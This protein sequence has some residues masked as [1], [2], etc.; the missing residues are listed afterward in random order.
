MSGPSA[1]GLASVSCRARGIGNRL[2]LRYTWS[3]NS[4]GG[5]RYGK[6][7]AADSKR[8]RAFRAQLTIIQPV[9]CERSCDSCSVSWVCPGQLGQRQD[10]TAQREGSETG[11]RRTL[12]WLL[13]IRSHN[14]LMELRRRARCSEKKRT[15][16]YSCGRWISRAG[17]RRFGRYLCGENLILMCM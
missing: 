2:G 3:G 4:R 7:R 5:A 17:I 13:Y 10:M 15:V 11:I 14:D 8:L 9:K 12:I 1:R 16:D 6:V